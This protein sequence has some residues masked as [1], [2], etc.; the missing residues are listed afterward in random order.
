MR[1]S[2]SLDLLY[3]LVRTNFKLK[4]N[5]KI[6]SIIYTWRYLKDIE[7]LKKYISYIDYGVLGDFQEYNKNIN[8]IPSSTNQYIYNFTNN[9]KIQPIKKG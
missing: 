3:E 5:D 1:K 7:H 8:Y 6:C 9:K 4:Y 2:N